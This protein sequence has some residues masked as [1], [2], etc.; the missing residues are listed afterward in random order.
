MCVCI[1]V[2]VCLGRTCLKCTRANSAIPDSTAQCLIPLNQALKK[3]TIKRGSVVKVDQAGKKVG[4]CTRTACVHEHAC[5][6]A[7]MHASA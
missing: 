3:G 7:C 5:I 1:C 6:Y 2:C 4:V